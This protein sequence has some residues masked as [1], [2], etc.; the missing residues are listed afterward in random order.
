M[1]P[2]RDQAG[3]TQ[4]LASPA[5]QLAR[6]S[7]STRPP[8]HLNRRDGGN[9]LLEFASCFV[10]NGHF[11]SQ[12]SASSSSGC[13]L[14]MAAITFLPPSNATIMS[15]SSTKWH[16]SDQDWEPHRA[17]IK[18]LYLEEDR[19]L[20]EVMAIMQRDHGFK[21]TSGPGSTYVEILNLTLRQCKYVQES[22][23]EMEAG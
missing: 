20:K 13:P 21:A 5:L 22:H 16:T 12:R 2:W 14:E 18:Q 15:M 10:P 4:W 11:S 1:I 7:T 23:N 9:V 6:R 19:P 3:G 17:R 8:L